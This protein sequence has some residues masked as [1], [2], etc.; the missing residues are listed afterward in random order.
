MIN[1]PKNNLQNVSKFI[2]INNFLNKLNSP[3]KRNRM[4]EWK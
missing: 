1:K 3:I 4:T 2:P